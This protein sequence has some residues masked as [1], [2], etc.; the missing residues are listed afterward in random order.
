MEKIASQGIHNF[1][2]VERMIL[3]RTLF[4]IF[5][6]W[7]RDRFQ[8]ELHG[9][10]DSYKLQLLDIV[11]KKIDTRDF[12]IICKVFDLKNYL[13]SLSCENPYV[14]GD[15]ILKLNVGVDKVFVVIKSQIL[16]IQRL[17]RTLD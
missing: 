8:V 12:M 2:Y 1:G 14:R 4:V 6:L 16:G 11:G 15:S 5:K 17:I 10:S 7:V 13:R 9:F 3:E